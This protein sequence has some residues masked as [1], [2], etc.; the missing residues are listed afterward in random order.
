MEPHSL[1]EVVVH[2]TLQR[3]VTGTGCGKAINRDIKMLD[4]LTE[5]EF[6]DMKQRFGNV[7]ELVLKQ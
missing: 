2:Y 3:I 1:A 5:P 6:L 4:Q 7:L